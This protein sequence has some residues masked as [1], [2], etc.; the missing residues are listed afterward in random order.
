MNV[1]LKNPQPLEEDVLVCLLQRDDL[2][3]REVD[4][5]K[6]ILRWAL[7]KHPRA[8][9]SYVDV[10]TLSEPNIVGKG[11]GR[12]LSTDEWASARKL[13]DDYQRPTT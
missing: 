8:A 13:V 12:T 4:L 6:Y 3:I 5:W 7:D 2:Q 11:S 1:F 9:E 10:E